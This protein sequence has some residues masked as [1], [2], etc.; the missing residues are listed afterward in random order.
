MA[1]ARLAPTQPAEDVPIDLATQVSS[2]IEL[3]VLALAVAVVVLLVLIWWLARQVATLRTRLSSLTRGEEGD[4][5]DVLGAHLDR[6]YELG[7]EASSRH[8]P[9]T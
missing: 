7:R 4:L 2:N 3:I 5:S 1:A 8:S 6:V 9:A